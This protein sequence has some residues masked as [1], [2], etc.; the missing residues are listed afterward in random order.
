MKRLA[1]ATLLLASI[2]TFAQRELTLPDASPAAAVS[3]NLGVTKIDVNY[4]SPGV[5]ERKVWGE[6]VPYG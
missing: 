3:M 1:L 4:H 6:L 5:K 2:T